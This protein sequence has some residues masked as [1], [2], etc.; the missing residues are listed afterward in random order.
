MEYIKL[1]FKNFW[2]ATTD[3]PNE[4]LVI[5]RNDNG[6]MKRISIPLEDLENYEIDED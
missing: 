6:V 1:Y 5:F 3:I 2:F 4:N